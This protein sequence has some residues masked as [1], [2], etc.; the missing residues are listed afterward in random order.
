[1]PVAVNEQ[2]RPEEDTDRMSLE[3]CPN[4]GRKQFNPSTRKCYGCGAEAGRDGT[5]V[6][7]PRGYHLDENGNFR[8]AFKSEV[9]D[10]K[11]RISYHYIL[12]EGKITLRG[13]YP[14]LAEP[15]KCLHPERLSC[16]Y[17]DGFER[18]EFMKHLDGRWICE[19]S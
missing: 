10:G 6:S 11:L 8:S 15:P 17:G 2:I 14:K 9:R 5:I 19:T 3:K 16:N 1:V 12:E 4:C 18:C 7:V 13:E